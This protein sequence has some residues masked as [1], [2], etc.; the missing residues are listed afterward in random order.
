MVDFNSEIIEKNK[1]L[2]DSKNETLRTSV[3]VDRTKVQI[4]RL[5]N[6]KKA[7]FLVN[8]ITNKNFKLK[9]YDEIRFFD[10][11]KVNDEM[12]VSNK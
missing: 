12:K 1:D 6:G 8:T 3:S 7:T 9:K 11:S 4:S 10:F 2:L 5:E